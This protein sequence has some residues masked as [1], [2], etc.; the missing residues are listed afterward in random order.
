M[1][2]I[3]GIGSPQV[4]PIDVIK[5]SDLSPGDTYEDCFITL[6]YVFALTP[7]QTKSKEFPLSMVRI[8]EVAAEQEG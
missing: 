6:V 2:R 3:A 5:A 4:M 8:Q 1:S 7:I